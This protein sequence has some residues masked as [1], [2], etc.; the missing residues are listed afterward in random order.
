M[1]RFDLPLDARSLL[2]GESML[3]EN[4]NQN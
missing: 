2:V 4:N 1:L 3:R